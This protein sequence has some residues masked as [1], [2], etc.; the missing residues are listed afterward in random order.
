MSLT[1]IL[2]PF[3]GCVLG[4]VAIQAWG[5]TALD[6]ARKPTIDSVKISPDGEYLAATL[7]INDQ[8]SLGIIDLKSMKITGSLRFA[9][10][11]HVADYWWV[12]PRRVVAAMA[13]RNGPLDQPAY[14]GELVGINADGSDKTYLHGY[15]G[16]VPGSVY[17]YFS[18]SAEAS[19][20]W[21]YMLDPFSLAPDE[22]LIGVVYFRR[23]W[24]QDSQS[25]RALNVHTG[26]YR[27]VGALPVYAPFSVAFDRRGHPRLAEGLDASGKIQLLLHPDKPGSDWVR[28]DRKESGMTSAQ[29]FGTNADASLA[30]YASDEDSPRLCLRAF[31][32]KAGGAKLLS[33]NQRVDLYKP[34]MSA[35]RELPI[36]A[37]FEDGLPRVEI[38]APDHPE[39]KIL[40]LLLGAFPGQRVSITSRTRDGSRS[41]LL[42]DSDRN[43]GDFYLFDWAS[44]KVEY[45]LSRRDWIDHKQMRPMQPIRYKT[46]DGTDIDGY[47]TLPEGKAPQGFPLV[48]M[49]HGGPHGV[50]DFWSWDPWTQWLASRGYA[51][52]QVNFRGS[53]GYGAAH[54]QAGHRR[55][56]TLMQDDL[57]DAVR[58]AI[59]AG[60]ADAKRICIVGGSYGGY[61]A[62]MNAVR[63]PEL[64]RCA[65]ALAGVYD[66][67]SQIDDSDIDDSRMGRRYLEQV[68][69]TDSKLHLEQS[70][71]T[72]VDR[73]KVPVMIA[74]GTAD[75]RVPF[76]QA[77]KLRKALDKL[78]KPYEWH[79]YKGEAHGFYK[80]ENHEDFLLKLAD[81]LD[82]NI[83]SK[84][85]APAAAAE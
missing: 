63:E 54:S 35:D 56:G 69:G 16:K 34:I 24:D 73:L 67:A 2:S 30:F 10:G 44:A 33:C 47:L 62:L 52:L 70:P 79:P 55:W 83:G 29:V 71:I 76:N 59:A 57:A 14:T 65:A 82:R 23:G 50:R 40:Q 5:A 12:G 80:D 22:A 72:Y 27:Q 81:F 11:D 75:E 64:Y 4:F 17:D 13:R 68:L 45:L 31:D 8:I 74:H 49:P 28:V 53:D 85:A 15:R 9:R 18:R 7:P 66:L 19:Y 6:F 51:V 26:A 39:A 41:V 37:V 77:R 43:P 20:S 25:F 84:S 1:K 3:V 21:A 38:L 36:A 61:A 60:H 46:R 78:G 32:L 58:W 42:V 48:L